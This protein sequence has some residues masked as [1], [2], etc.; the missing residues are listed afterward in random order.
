MF[1]ARAHVF[2]ARRGTGGSFEN[3]GLLSVWYHAWLKKGCFQL[4]LKELL[5]LT[6]NIFSDRGIIF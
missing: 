2:L 5:I 6:E 3:V 4:V 1:A